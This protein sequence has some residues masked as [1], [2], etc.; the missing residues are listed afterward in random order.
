[1][2]KKKLKLKIED[3]E[4]TKNNHAS[5]LKYLGYPDNPLLAIRQVYDDIDSLKNKNIELQTE[6][7]LRDNEIGILKKDLSEA[8][9]LLNDV[10]SKLKIKSHDISHFDKKNT[11][12]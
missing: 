3:L 12:K 6:L 4:K 1:M 11:G 2:K 7:M 8:L 5:V 9:I 10:N